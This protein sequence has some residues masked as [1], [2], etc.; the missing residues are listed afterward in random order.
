MV[1]PIQF[2]GLATGIDTGSMI[3]QLVQLERMPIA[4]VQVRQKDLQTQQSKFNDLKNLLNTV[5]D[6]A[7]ALDRMDEVLT[8]SVKSADETIVRASATG[9]V[10]IGR[11]SIDVTSLATAERT[12]SNGFNSKVATGLFGD[13]NLSIQVGSGTAVD[14]AVTTEDTLESVAAK[15]NNSGA[16]VDASVIFDGTNFRLLVAG[17]Q[18]GAA[19]AITF[20][21]TGTSLGL[22]VGGNQYQAAA[23]AVFSIDNLPMTSATNTVS[24][25]ISGVTV[26]LLKSGTS[27]VD[28]QRDS[29]GFEAKMKEFVDAY[30]A[31]QKKINTESAFT[32]TARGPESLV[33]DSTLRAVQ[34][35]LRTLVGSQ[36]SGITGDYTTLASLGV[37]SLNDGQLKIDSTKLK[38][39]L[40]DDAEAVGRVLI[41]DTDNGTDGVMQL[42]QDLVKSFNE[43]PNGT[44]TARIKGIDRRV[45]DYDKQIDAMERRVDSY[46]TRLT[47]QFSAMEQLVSGLN[48]QGQQMLSVFGR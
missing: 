4:R 23:D 40:A 42:M 12:Y 6:K 27:I 2:S 10:G 3:K 47:A 17:E 18:T 46:E 38:A 11:Y 34:T 36:V 13:G 5:R 19:N 45:K 8:T 33:G 22:N 39:A 7:R 31:V 25:A 14:I 37:T 28:V 44:I 20:G 32:G 48:S 24:S 16:A 35:R 1:A 9:G 29:A 30:N 41:R 43:A 26:D 21:E 15:I